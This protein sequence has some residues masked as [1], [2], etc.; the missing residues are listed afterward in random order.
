[1]TAKRVSAYHAGKMAEGKKVD[2]DISNLTENSQ[3]DELTLLSIVEENPTVE[4]PFGRD[5]TPVTDASS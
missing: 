3:V 2:K 5:E 1:M 4:L